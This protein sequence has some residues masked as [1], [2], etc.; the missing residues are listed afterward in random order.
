MAKISFDYDGTTDDHFFGNI[1]TL[2]EKIQELIVTFIEEGHEVNIVTRRYGEGT[3]EHVKVFETA[4]KLGIPKENV[5]FTNRSWKF[6][7]LN[8]LKV[9]YHIDD[10]E[11]DI[12]NI[13]MYCTNTVGHLFNGEDSIRSFHKLCNQNKEN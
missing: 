13:K 11:T 3:E 10:D 7:K 4:E 6:H 2:K 9:D 5:Y 8:E 12:F 1:N